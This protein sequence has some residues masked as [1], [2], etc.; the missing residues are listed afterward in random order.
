MGIGRGPTAGFQRYHA[1][2]GV[3]CSLAV[4]VI[5]VKLHCQGRHALKRKS[6]K[7]RMQDHQW[8]VGDCWCLDVILPVL[9]LDKGI[10]SGFG[11]VQIHPERV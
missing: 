3:F 7:C 6:V 5:L 11:Y 9:S 10:L 4:A 1:G 8:G 2:G